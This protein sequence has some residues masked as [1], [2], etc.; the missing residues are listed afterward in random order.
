MM[1]L[2]DF[3]VQIYLMKLLNFN[4]IRRKML[5]FLLKDNEVYLKIAKLHKSE[6]TY[7]NIT[8]MFALY[9]N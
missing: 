7:F 1:L 4:L 2:F 6:I 5:T 9:W 8:T 3:Y